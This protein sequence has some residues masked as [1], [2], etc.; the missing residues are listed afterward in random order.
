MKKVPIVIVLLS[1]TLTAH[2]D[3]FQSYYLAWSGASFGNAATATGRMTLDLTTLPNPTPGNAEINIYND[4]QSLTLTVTGASSGNGTWTKADVYYTYWWTG[5][6][7][8]NMYRDLI[9]QPT[10]GNPWGTPDGLSGDFNLFIND[11]GPVGTYFFT[12]TTN[13]GAGDTMLLTEF[14]LPEPSSLALLGA[15]FFTIAAALAFKRRIAPIAGRP[16]RNA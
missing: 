7:T 6:V 10:T 4:I 2:A 12:M 16:F 1:L 15:G 3:I 11:P 5:G 9:G 8:L 13:G 14:S